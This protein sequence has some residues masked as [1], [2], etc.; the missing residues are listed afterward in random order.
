MNYRI[1]KI[2]G[3]SKTGFFSDLVHTILPSV[4]YLNDNNID[5]F[6]I[7]W[8]NNLYQSQS[9]NLYDFFFKNNKTFDNYDIELNVTNCPYGFFFTEYCSD[10]KLQ[11]GSE[12]VKF[13]KLDEC[14]VYDKLHP[15]FNQNYKI[16]GVQQRQTDHG[17]HAKLID[18]H[19]Y[20][21]I[22]DEYFINN[23]F[24]YIF[25][26]TDSVTSLENFKQYFGDKLI[27]NT[28]II[29]SKTNDAIH[30]M[31]S[32]I[33]DKIKLAEEVLLDAYSLSLTDYKFICNSNVSTFSLLLNYN[34]TNYTYIDK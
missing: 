30:F 24:D 11:R 9:Y 33:N 29:R 2:N 12:I 25:L 1:S 31:E 20:I 5:S 19:A 15:F 16:L 17:L 4:I 28:D 21:K 7:H 18:D 26:I 34:P 27:Y 10:D 22:V 14:Y 32:N 23:N 8:E 13:L 6:H 3:L